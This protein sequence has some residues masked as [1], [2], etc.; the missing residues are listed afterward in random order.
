MQLDGTSS[1]GRSAAQVP[2]NK[3]LSISFSKSLC[4][5]CRPRTSLLAFL[6]GVYKIGIQRVSAVSSF[7]SL[8]TVFTHPQISFYHGIISLFPMSISVALCLNTRS[9]GCLNLSAAWSR[10]PQANPS[11]W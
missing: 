7:S 10:F 9:G 3:S 4:Q 1:C 8:S 11:S 5:S 2:S 6:P